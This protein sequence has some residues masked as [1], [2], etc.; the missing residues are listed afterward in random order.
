MAGRGQTVD[1]YIRSFPKPIQKQLRAIRRAIRKAVP[2]A[3]ERISYRMPY[4]A[5]H[6]RLLY[7]AAFRDHLSVFVPSAET[8]R[9]F[10][11]DLARY[12]QSGR[13]TVRFPLDAPVP[14]RLIGRIARLRA[15]E[16][17][18]RAARRRRP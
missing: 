5:F 1:D 11:R 3:D 12:D 8:L 2:D 18:T 13:G 14:E 10:R 6:G 17:R 15:A 4:Y 16:N 7:F 9:A